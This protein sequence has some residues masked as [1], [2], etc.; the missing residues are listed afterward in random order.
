MPGGLDDWRNFALRHYDS[1]KRQNPNATFKDALVA[2]APLYRQMRNKSYKESGQLASLQRRQAK[3]V[4]G[5]SRSN[6]RQ[7]ANISDAHKY[8]GVLKDLKFDYTYGKELFEDDIE[9]EMQR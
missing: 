5:S 1:M 4:K 7:M 6:L 2:A 9:W 8:G 3:H